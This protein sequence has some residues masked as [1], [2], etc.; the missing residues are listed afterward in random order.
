MLHVRMDSYT[1]TADIHVQTTLRGTILSNFILSYIITQT[2]YFVLFY[3][4]KYS[5]NFSHSDIITIDQSPNSDG[6]HAL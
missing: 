3:Q 1:T 2:H 5:R 6:V 4:L